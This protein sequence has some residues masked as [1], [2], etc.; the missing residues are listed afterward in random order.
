M[1]PEDTL[2]RALRTTLDHTDFGALGAKYEGKVRDNYTTGD[3]RRFLVATD[4]ISAFDRVL[5]TLPL[6]GQVLNLLAA[7]WF[8]AT[9]HIAPN[10]VISVP[11][12]NV[13]EAVECTPLPVEMVVRAYVTGVTSTSIWTHYARG[14]R[15]FCGHRL[16]DGLH[17]NDRLPAPILTPSTKAPKGGHDVSASREEILA[18]GVISARDFDE[19]AEMV[20]AL[21]A[22][23]QKRCEERGLILVD[24]K[25]EL[26]KT[27]DGRIVVIDEIHTP[28]SSRFWFART[29]DE[30]RARGEEPESFDKEYVRRWLAGTGFTGDGP[31]PTIPDEVRVEAARRYIEAFE[32]IT[33]Q[34]FVPD[35]EDPH[36]RIRRNLKIAG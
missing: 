31:I 28:D 13:V 16:P 26:G 23:G 7:H 25:Y 19:A 33:G 18:E 2:K 14:E 32:T 15:V 12:P 27:K 11:D 22:F 20:M 29:Y 17:K 34:A 30:R 36:V 8:E 6:K 5:G 4:R 9:K 3:G 21:F 24:T 1:V 10:H 35:L